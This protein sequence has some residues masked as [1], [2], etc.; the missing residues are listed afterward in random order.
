[1]ALKCTVSH[2]GT[3]EKVVLDT[4]NPTVRQALEAA[5]IAANSVSV[6]IDGRTVGLD[7]SLKDGD[8]LE[9]TPTSAKVG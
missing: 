9:V 1:M 4:Q 3:V 8:V 5:D 6:A 2:M 7:S